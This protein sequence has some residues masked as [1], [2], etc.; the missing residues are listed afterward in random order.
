[1]CLCIINPSHLISDDSPARARHRAGALTADE[2]DNPTRTAEQTRT[3]LWWA[4]D[5][6]FRI[7]VPP[8]LYNSL[9]DDVVIAQ[10]GS[11]APELATGFQLVRLYAMVNMALADSG[12]AVCFYSVLQC[13]L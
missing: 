7:G 4:Y 6:G 3:G 9:V 10:L 11:N 1:M 8:R 5:G 12:I 2:G 13:D